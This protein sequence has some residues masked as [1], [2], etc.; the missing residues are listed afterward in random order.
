[1][2][3][4]TAQFTRKARSGRHRVPKSPAKATPSRRSAPPPIDRQALR[5]GLKSHVRTVRDAMFVAIT[6]GD[7]LC[8]QNADGEVQVAMVLR[9]Y[10]SN[11]L[12]RAIQETGVL[13][14][15]LD[16]K[17]DVDP[18]SDEVTSLADPDH[19]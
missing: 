11:R 9:A 16:G 5:D 14:A 17:T 7:A 15:L 18:E 10:C 8:H 3:M 2:I 13:L 1:M 12:Y 4:A 19:L 6:C